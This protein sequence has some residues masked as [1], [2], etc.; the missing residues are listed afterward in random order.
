MKQFIG[1]IVIFA[2]TFQLSSVRAQN[3]V[4]TKPELQNIAWSPDG[5]RIAGLYQNSQIAIWSVNDLINPLVTFQTKQADTLTWTPDSQ[6]LIV[7]GIDAAE[8]H[9][10]QMS[11]TKWDA[12]S[13]QKVD[14]LMSFQLDT[15]FDFNPYGY[16]IFPILALDSTTTKAAFSFG[17]GSVLIS[18]GSQVLHLKNVNTTNSV[19]SMI[20][21]PNGRQLAIVYGSSDIYN[22]QIF[23]VENDELILNIYQDL[24][25]FIT[26]WGWDS[27]GTYLA[28][29]SMRFTCCEGWSNIGVYK[30]EKG[31]D[32]L[33]SQF[34]RPNIE[35]YAAPIAWNPSKLILAIATTDAIEVYNPSDKKLLFRV[36]VN[37]AKDIEWSPDGKQIASVSGD[38]TIKIWDIRV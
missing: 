16:N 32:Y 27:S 34:W 8:D 11:V 29:S 12:S 7:Q 23:N 21:S 19:L 30:I 26:D 28:T 6:Q 2:V 24:Q 31:D 25:Y 36:A 14:T 20:W 37:E 13:G 10:L 4:T 33:D 5:T 18:D 1:F 17:G 15:R 38:G 22:I 35:R 9:L 3:D